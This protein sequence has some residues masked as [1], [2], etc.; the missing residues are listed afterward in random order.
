MSVQVIVTIVFSAESETEAEE[1]IKS[2]NLQPGTRV[3]SQM[4]AMIDSAS[5]IVGDSGEIEPPQPPEPPADGQ[6]PET[7]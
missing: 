5:G 3:S 4:S 2:W 7:A 1:A 6:A